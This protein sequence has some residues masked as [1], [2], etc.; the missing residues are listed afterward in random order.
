[1]R[2]LSALETE[3]VPSSTGTVERG[4]AFDSP[5]LTAG[6]FT[7]AANSIMAAESQSNDRVLFVHSGRAQATVGDSTFTVGRGAFVHVPSRVSV[8]F[9]NEDEKHTCEIAFVAAK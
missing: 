4:V 7:I 9:R 3:S 8:A 5:H 6:V 1:M 2:A